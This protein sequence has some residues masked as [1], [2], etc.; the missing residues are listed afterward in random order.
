MPTA[1]TAYNA[2]WQRR[3]AE[4]AGISQVLYQAGVAAAIVQDHV[5][6]CPKMI[7]STM[8]WQLQLL[9]QLLL[10][11]EAITMA[12]ITMMTVTLMQLPQLLQL[13]LPRLLKTVQ[14]PEA[15]TCNLA[16]PLS[17]EL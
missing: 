7:A 17:S 4:A 14:L 8:I 1:T 3:I 11:Q 5:L 16:V 6:T 13:Q 10:H 2:T 9:S 15:F 12:T